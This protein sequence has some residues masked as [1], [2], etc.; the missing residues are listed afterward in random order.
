MS[1]CIRWRDPGLWPYVQ[2]HVPAGYRAVTDLGEALT[3][4]P[5]A[6]ATLPA[7]KRE[8]YEWLWETMLADG[9]QPSGLLVACL[10][11]LATSLGHTSNIAPKRFGTFCT[12]NLVWRYV[13]GKLYPYGWP[14]APGERSRCYIILAPDKSTE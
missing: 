6:F 7:R 8:Q 10:G 11:A 1:H 9:I 14:G 5:A 2:Q 4:G 12:N 3:I 13:P